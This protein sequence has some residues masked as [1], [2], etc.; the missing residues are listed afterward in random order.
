M[1]KNDI[2]Y[3][4]FDRL[5]IYAKKD[6]TDKIIECYQSFSWELI[7]NSENERYEDT[8]DLT[9]IRPHKIKNKDYLQYNQIE[10]ENIIIN[11]GKIEKK[12]HAKSTSFG[13]LLGIFS[14]SFLIVGLY[15]L[16]YSNISLWLSLITTIIGFSCI[17]LSTFL[18][19]KMYKKENEKFDYDYKKLNEE[20]VAFCK[21]IRE[22][23]RG[24]ENE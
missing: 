2:D 10:M 3:A 18:S 22:K 7:D 8:K 15:L 13:L 17:C 21:K 11:I 20:L 24:D 14:C 23:T 1:R 19:I 12:K 9:F 5:D 6:K 16:F 4:N